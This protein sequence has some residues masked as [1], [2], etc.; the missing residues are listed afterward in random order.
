MLLGECHSY[1][2]YLFFLKIVTVFF[3]WGRGNHVIFIT[4]YN[5]EEIGILEHKPLW[6]R[7]GRV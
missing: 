1:K 2:I 3:Y 4:E 7:I 6:S 5:T